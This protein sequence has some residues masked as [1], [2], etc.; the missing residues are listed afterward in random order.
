MWP[1]MCHLL[2]KFQLCS[3]LQH[4]QLC[5]SGSWSASR[6]QPSRHRRSFLEVDH[7]IM[8]FHPRGCRSQVLWRR[9]LDSRDL[10]RLSSLDF[11][12][13][14][15]S[16][17]SS[18]W[19]STVSSFW[20]YTHYHSH[21]HFTRP[22]CCLLC[23]HFT[24]AHHNDLRF[25]SVPSFKLPWPL[26]RCFCLRCLNMICHRTRDYPSLWPYSLD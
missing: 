1:L 9:S 10:L 3:G 23:Q 4:F 20:I 15:I 26:E 7:S 14:L 19:R 11:I 2:C 16:F 18:L 24:L 21:N 17:A 25:L 12:D 22:S 6:L 8:E 5:R 13:F